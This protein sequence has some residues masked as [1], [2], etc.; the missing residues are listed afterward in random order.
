MKDWQPIATGGYR[1]EVDGLR[2]YLKYIGSVWVVACELVALS[3]GDGAMG[4]GQALDWAEVVVREH[5]GLQR[6]WFEG[7]H[8]QTGVKG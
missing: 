8:Q 4:E 7:G 5:R 2:Y 1:C 3:S 6:A